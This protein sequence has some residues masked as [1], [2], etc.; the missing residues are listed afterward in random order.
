M[1]YSTFVGCLSQLPQMIQSLFHRGLTMEVQQIL[2]TTHLSDHA[3][4]A[5]G[6]ATNLASKLGANLHLVHFAGAIHSF[7]SKAS[8]EALLDTLKGIGLATPF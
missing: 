3:R 5:Y 4:G 2:L 8:R 6:C 7:L 1:R